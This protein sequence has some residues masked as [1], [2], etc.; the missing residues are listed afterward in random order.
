VLPVKVTN[1]SWKASLTL[2]FNWIFLGRAT[3][4]YFKNL[5]HINNSLLFLFSS[6]ALAVTSELSVLRVLSVGLS[7][8]LT[9]AE[10][11]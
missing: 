9:G 1:N 6:E 4:I 10:V 11:F 2:C 5:L 8:S 7:L 3:T